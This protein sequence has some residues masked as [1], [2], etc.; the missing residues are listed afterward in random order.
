MD[1]VYNPLETRL[2]KAAAG[3]GCKTVDGLAMLVNQGA[4]QFEWWT[5]K[6]AP[7]KIMRLAVLENLP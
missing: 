6:K 3:A 1:I 7:R 4:R 5:G 2:L